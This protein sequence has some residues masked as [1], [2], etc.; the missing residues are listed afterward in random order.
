MEDK[1]E[2]KTWKKIK[3]L[4]KR[5]KRFRKEGVTEKGRKMDRKTT[6]NA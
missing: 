3:R 5:R 4:G 6:K 1:K 2:K